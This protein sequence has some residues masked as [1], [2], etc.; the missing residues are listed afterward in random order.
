MP[1]ALNRPLSPAVTAKK[2]KTSSVPATAPSSGRA[3][4]RRSSGTLAHPFVDEPEPAMPFAASDGR[5]P[6]IAAGPACSAQRLPCL[7]RS[8][9]EA[10]VSLVTKPGPVG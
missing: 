2:T 4:R 6:A 1:L 7:A 10:A 5:R 9:T 3:S 8:I